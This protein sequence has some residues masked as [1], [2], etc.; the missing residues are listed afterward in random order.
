MQRLKRMKKVIELSI[1]TQANTFVQTRIEYM[2]FRNKIKCY[3]HVCN[4]F[5]LR[6]LVLFAIR[7]QCGCDLPGSEK[8]KENSTKTDTNKWR[9]KQKSKTLSPPWRLF[10]LVASLSFAIFSVFFIVLS[11]LVL[12][13]FKTNKT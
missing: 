12:V 8:F 5:D 1:L 9:E 13:S 3:L 11:F 7:W 6:C 10:R 4:A 2:S